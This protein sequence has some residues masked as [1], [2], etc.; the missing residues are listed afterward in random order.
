MTDSSG[1][2]SPILHRYIPA[3]GE[4]PKILKGYRDLDTYERIARFIPDVVLPRLNSLELRLLEVAS[5]YKGKEIPRRIDG[6]HEGTILIEEVFGNYARRLRRRMHG[7]EGVPLSFKDLDQASLNDRLCDI[8]Y[9]LVGAFSIEA[10]IATDI[11]HQF[12]SEIG[13]VE[14]AVYD[15]ARV[16]SS[17]MPH[18]K[19]PVEYEQVV[20]LWKRYSADVMALI[21]AQVNEHQ[22]DST[23]AHVPRVAFENMIA[24]AYATKRLD[25]ALGNLRINPIN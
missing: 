13:E 10:N 9:Q 3:D 11:R 7:L 24:L 1:A 8:V 12:R 20:S 22:E 6:R 4:L 15:D 2:I 19:N 18:K 21:M 17:T 14:H 5:K 23:N 25:V 16:G